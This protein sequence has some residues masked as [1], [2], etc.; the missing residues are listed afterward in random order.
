MSVDPGNN[1][2]PFTTGSVSPQLP[3]DPP[4]ASTDGV[5]AT[6]RRA[7]PSAPQPTPKP[8]RVHTTPIPTMGLQ[9]IWYNFKKNLPWVSDPKRPALGMK[10][11][12]HDKR[13]IEDYYANDVLAARI[14]YANAYI[15]FLM[16]LGLQPILTF[17]NIKSGSKTTCALYVAAL[18]AEISR[19]FVLVIPTTKNTATSTI[20]MMAGITQ[21]RRITV[22]ELSARIDE[23]GVYHA[24]S[25]YVPRTHHGVGVIVEDKNMALASTDQYDLERFDKVLRTIRPIVDVIILDHGND[26]IEPNSIGLRGIRM[27]DVLNFVCML[28]TPIST[29]SMN[30]TIHGYFTDTATPE[31]TNHSFSGERMRTSD[32]VKV[33]NVIA[34]G[35][36]PSDGEVDFDV[37]TRYQNQSV[38]APSGHSW[39]GNGF[40]VPFDDYIADRSVSI[41]D[42][43]KIAPETYLAYAE[44]AIANLERAAE[45][46]GIKNVGASIPDAPTFTMPPPPERFEFDS[47][48]ELVRK[49]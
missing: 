6:G 8:P 5:Q 22:R 43:A 25:K 27:S 3:E 10:E 29:R 42:L 41:T 45:L 30:T 47:S 9:A 1:N 14:A 21:G 49:I 24:L 46:E 32:K 28:E 35:W 33:S 20:G 2:A 39:E 37:L 18:I 36:R 38:T 17:S 34:S 48:G 11:C 26:D 23:F 13:T 4:Q 44:I 31:V 7:R 40:V 19:K 12:L 16:D 15:K